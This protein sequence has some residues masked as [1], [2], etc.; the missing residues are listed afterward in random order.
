[1]NFAEFLAATG[2]AERWV[3]ACPLAYS[4]GNAPNKRDVLGTLMLRLLVTTAPPWMRATRCTS[5]LGR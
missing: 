1:M 4:S 3:S 2:V 5:A